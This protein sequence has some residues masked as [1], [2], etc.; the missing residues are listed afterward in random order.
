[1]KTDEAILRKWTSGTH[2]N[3]FQMFLELREHGK[4]LLCP[5]NTFSTHGETAW[6][7]PLYKTKQENLIEEWK[8]H[9]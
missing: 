8:K 9:L 4:A 3:D 1:L 6:L 7:A 5:L 2:P